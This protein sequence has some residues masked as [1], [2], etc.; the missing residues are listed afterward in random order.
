MKVTPKTMMERVCPYATCREAFVSSMRLAMANPA[1]LP[2]PIRKPVP[3]DFVCHLFR[4]FKKRGAPPQP[5]PAGFIGDGVN[6]CTRKSDTFASVLQGRVAVADL[7]GDGLFD[8]LMGNATGTILWYPN[9]GTAGKPRFDQ[10]RLLFTDDD[11]AIDVGWSRPRWPSIGTMMATWICSSAPKRSVS[12]TSKILEMRSLP[13]FDEKGCRRPTASA[14]D[15]SMRRAKKTQAARSIRW[16]TTECRKSPIGTATAISI[17]WRRLHHGSHLVL[18]KHRSQCATY[19]YANVS[20]ALQADGR[21]L[22]VGWCAS[23]CVVDLDSDGDLDL[24]SGAMQITA[25]GGDGGSSDKFLW[26]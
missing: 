6:R 23:P 22:D 21:D 24:I 3:T 19:A 1:I 10:P 14:A 7:D 13:S 5:A 18:R 11:D 17:Y 20:R 2:G 26:Y 9:H 25:T 16:I 12:S 8:L 15:S 4:R